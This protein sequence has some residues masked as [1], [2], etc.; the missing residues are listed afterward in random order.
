L[1]RCS[2]CGNSVVSQSH[3]LSVAARQAAIVFKIKK[4]SAIV[5]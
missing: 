3:F 1:Q 2:D 5:L 4:P